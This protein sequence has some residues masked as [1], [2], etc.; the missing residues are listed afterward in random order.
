MVR[1]RPRNRRACRSR[2]EKGRKAFEQEPERYFALDPVCGMEVNPKS[3]KGGSFEHEGRTFYFCNMKCLA[4][5]QA[6]PRHFLDRGPGAMP[7]P[8]PPPAP[9]PGGEVMWVCPMDPEVREKEPVPCPICGMAL[10]PL[11]VGGMPS[12][13]GRN[14]E[15]ENMSRRLWI[16][17]APVAVLVLAMSHALPAA[18]SAAHLLGHRVNAWLQLI[19]SAPAVLWGGWPFF[20]R[21]WLSLKTRHFNMFTLIGLGTGAAFGFS[22]L[23]T[24]L[25]AGAFPAAFRGAHGAVPIYFESVAVIVELVLLGQVLELR[26]RGRASGAIKALLGLAPRRPGASSRTVG[27]RTSLSRTS[28]SRRPW[29]SWSGRAAALPRGTRPPASTY[30]CDSPRCGSCGRSARAPC[31][32]GCRL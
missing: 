21:A 1:T 26:A 2:C 15:L 18:W 30:R 31:T 6:D 4:K 8:A 12:A 14:P 28:G 20:E 3:P 7:S 9:P 19:L 23:A 29:R 25:P 11:V 17:L 10:E 16:G 32:R 27:N 24:I 5:F 13:D 22:A